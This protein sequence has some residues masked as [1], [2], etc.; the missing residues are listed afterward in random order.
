MKLPIC[1]LLASRM[2]LQ[3]VVIL[4]LQAAL[5]PSSLYLCALS[6]L[7]DL[8]VRDFFYFRHSPTIP[9]SLFFSVLSGLFCTMD[10]RNPFAFYRFRT[11]SI[12]MGVVLVSLAKIR[13]ALPILITQLARDDERIAPP[14]AHLCTRIAHFLATTP[15]LA[16]LAFFMGGGGINTSIQES[17]NLK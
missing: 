6:R 5:F 10:A 3:G 7:C 14:R 11:L 15:F 2:V 13:G 4:S 8:C 1:R 12:A 16:T 9:L 17:R